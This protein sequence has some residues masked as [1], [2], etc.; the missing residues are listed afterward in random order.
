MP[1]QRVSD[2][3]QSLGRCL[4]HGDVFDTFYEIFLKSDPRIPEQFVGTEWEEQKRLL[5]QGV[6]NVIGYFDESFTAQSALE[7]IRY[8]HGRDRLNIPPALYE[9]WMDSMIEAVRQHDPEFDSVLEKEWREVLR[10]GT[11]FVKAGYEE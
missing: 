7:R 5:R 11:D 4:H 1:S 6:N 2:V 3:K 9:L 10:K 8:T